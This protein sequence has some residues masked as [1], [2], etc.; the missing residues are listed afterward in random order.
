MN[1]IDFL[2][3]IHD[4]ESFDPYAKIPAK[5]GELFVSRTPGDD[6]I[7]PRETMTGEYVERNSRI[8]E[9]GSGNEHS[10]SVHLSARSSS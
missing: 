5:R 4:E 3:N 9:E 7:Y 10:Y 8:A 1:S 2:L 6:I